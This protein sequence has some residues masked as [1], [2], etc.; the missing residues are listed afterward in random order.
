MLQKVPLLCSL[1]SSLVVD[2]SGEFIVVRIRV[3]VL[4]DDLRLLGHVRVRLV[5]VAGRM[6]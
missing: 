5:D 6:R 3:L 4:H 1:L 2:E